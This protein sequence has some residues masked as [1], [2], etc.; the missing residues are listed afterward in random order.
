M[1]TDSDIIGIFGIALEIIGFV[2]LL[3]YDYNR[4]PTPHDAEKWKEK[5]KPRYPEW[6]K[7]TINIKI[8]E[9]YNSSFDTPKNS[10]GFIRLLI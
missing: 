2:L 4:R 9:E 7:D 8:N 10:F 3:K 5:H 6:I 1:I